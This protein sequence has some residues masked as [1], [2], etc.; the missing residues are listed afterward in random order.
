MSYAQGAEL[1]NFGAFVAFMGVNAAAFWEY[2]VRRRQHG[3]Q[4]VLPPALGFLVCFYIWLHL[5]SPA[6]VAGCSWLLLGALYGWHR[7]VF[8]KDRNFQIGLT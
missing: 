8:K 7:G 3:W 5:S 4:Y 1:L 6:K 2:C